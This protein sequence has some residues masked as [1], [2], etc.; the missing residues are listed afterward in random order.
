MTRVDFYLID[1]ATD[2]GQDI[3]VC[4]LV[5]KAFRL[6]HRLFI[7]TP[8]VSHAQRLDRLLADARRQ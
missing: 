2:G 1:N 4:K 6:G 8:D 7:L 3:A 5:H